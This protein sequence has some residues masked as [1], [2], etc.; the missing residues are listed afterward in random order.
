M[1]FKLYIVQWLNNYR[2]SRLKLVTTFGKLDV[3]PLQEPGSVKNEILSTAHKA[4]YESAGLNTNIFT[5]DSKE[6]LE[7]SITKDQSFMW[8]YIEQITNFYNLTINNLYNFKG[9]QLEFSLLPVTH[10]NYPHMLELYQKW[11]SIMC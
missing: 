3:H 11:G 9:Y 2:T 8:K 4:I 5:A 6:A 1:R 10:Y 7:Y